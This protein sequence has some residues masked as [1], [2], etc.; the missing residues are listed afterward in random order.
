VVDLQVLAEKADPA[1]LKFGKIVIVK[2]KVPYNRLRSNLVANYLQLMPGTPGT[3]WSG[4]FHEIM[5][6]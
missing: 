5:L 3:E 6:D 2:R 1:K 4:T